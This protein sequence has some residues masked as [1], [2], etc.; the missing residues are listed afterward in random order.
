MGRK[1]LPVTFVTLERKFCQLTGQN[2]KIDNK[3]PGFAIYLPWY[4][5]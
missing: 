5:A 3:A 1:C 2:R 4:V